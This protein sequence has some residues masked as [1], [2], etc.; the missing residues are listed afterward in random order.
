MPDDRRCT[1]EC[2]ALLGG[3]RHR[4]V[5]PCCEVE[6]AGQEIEPESPRERR[7]AE[8]ARDADA[9]TE[10]LG[11]EGNGGK[12]VEVAANGLG[13]EEEPHAAY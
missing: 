1:G 12:G 13:G 6:S 8:T 9:M 11:R 10:S 3:K 2:L 7:D 5:D 4:R